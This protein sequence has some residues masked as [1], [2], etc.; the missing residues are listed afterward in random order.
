[1]GSSLSFSIPSVRAGLAQIKRN[2]S[3]ARERFG[4]H[5]YGALQAQLRL[6]WGRCH[7]Q[8]SQTGASWN[9]H[10]ARKARR[11]SLGNAMARKAHAQQQP[12]G[13]ALL[14][15]LSTSTCFRYLKTLLHLLP[16]LIPTA[17]L[18]VPLVHL[19]RTLEQGVLTIPRRSSRR[20]SCQSSL[21]SWSVKY[22]G[23]G[24]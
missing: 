8:G 15:P 12:N 16:P 23:A 14:V 24:S 4:S 9:G 20:L 17:P 18:L 22:S 7:G 2:Q 21:L 11:K 13:N 3:E 19:D 1:M 10:V 6:G 5:I